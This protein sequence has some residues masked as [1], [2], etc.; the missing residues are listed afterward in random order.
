[1]MIAGDIVYAALTGS[2]GVTAIAGDS[3]QAAGGA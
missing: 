3:G 1:M 2:A